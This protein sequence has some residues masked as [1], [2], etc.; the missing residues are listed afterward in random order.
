ML[1]KT[2]Q[3]NT[4]EDVYRPTIRGCS[5]G[6]CPTAEGQS[7]DLSSLLVVRET[8]PIGDTLALHATAVEDLDRSIV[9]AGGEVAVIVTDLDSET[10]ATY[11]RSAR[12]GKLKMVLNHH[13]VHDAELIRWSYST[14]HNLTPPQPLP[15]PATT[16]INKT[17]TQNN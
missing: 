15:P 11:Q 1:H 4:P 10:I 14:I 3:Y 5:Q 9:R 16:T 12:S 17:Q 6:L 2:L 7:L 13:S 8:R